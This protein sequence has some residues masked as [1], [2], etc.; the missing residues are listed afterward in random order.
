MPAVGEDIAAVV[1]AARVRAFV[2]RSQEIDCFRAAL[3][4]ENS[5]RI[6]FVHG[7]G[8]LGKTTLL[9]RMRILAESTGRTVLMVSGDDVESARDTLSDAT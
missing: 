3:A 8:G 2:G 1:D 4:G 7:S 5:C 6:L 9:Q